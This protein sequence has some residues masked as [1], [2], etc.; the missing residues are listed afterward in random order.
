M[1]YILVLNQIKLFHHKDVNKF[2]YNNNPTTKPSILSQAH[3]LR[4]EQDIA[5]EHGLLNID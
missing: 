5:M 1:L 3:C 2:I 4:N